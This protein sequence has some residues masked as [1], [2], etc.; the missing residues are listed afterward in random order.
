[1]CLW[2]PNWPIQRLR[3]VQRAHESH[4]VVL[5]TQTGSR[6]AIVTHTSDE[7]I[8][9]GV[10]PGMPLADAQALL[11]ATASPHPP[12][13]SDD[14][15][16]S[17][18]HSLVH[19]ATHL[20]EADLEHL[21]TLA[22]HCQ[23]RY[24]PLVGLEEAEMPES[25]L[26][27]VTG[28][29][30]LFGGEVAL[31]EEISQDFRQNHF[32]VRIALAD[33]IGA[34]WAFAHYG[35]SPT[36]TAKS[37]SQV[38]RSQVPRPNTHASRVSDSPTHGTQPPHPSAIFHIPHSSSPCG[39]TPDNNTS[40]GP[41]SAA[42][43]MRRLPI[44]AL[45]LPARIVKTLRELDLYQIGQ[46]QDLPRS[47]LPSRFGPL[48]LQRLD[49]ALGNAVELLRLEQPPDPITAGREFE[50]PLTSQK[51][52]QTILCE[53]LTD[54]LEQLTSRKLGV[55]QLKCELEIPAEKPSDHVEPTVLSIGLLRPSQQLRQLQELVNMRLEHASLPKEISAVRLQ[56]DVT[57]SLQNRQTALFEMDSQ[58]EN[59]IAQEN[60]INRLSNRL[61]RQAVVRPALYPDAQPEY[62]V[63]YTPWLETT[64]A[65]VST[66]A[67]TRRKASTPGSP[68][69]SLVTFAPARLLILRPSVLFLQPEEIRTWALGPEGPPVRFCWQNR[70]HTVAYSWG[71]ERI[72]TGWW[73]SQAAQR[74]YYRVETTTGRR[75]WL[76]RRLD[77]GRWLLHGEY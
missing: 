74:D 54:I 3:S 50:Y 61:G 75:F 1:M 64:P 55:L 36:P 53:L 8:R 39:R 60:L 29:T 33:T 30:H 71:P 2:L 67:T 17:S 48:V 21:Q 70:E 66:P 14:K 38:S 43:D 35:Q 77:T 20:P 56:A 23:Q 25:L 16:G 52:L 32:Q 59:R 13:S 15:T 49:Q 63:R 11:P 24:T 68:A 62:A 69:P 19:F 73:R 9:L 47:S 40:R 22:Y 57:A 46:L 12:S 44:E 42:F 41:K 10:T 27:D 28:C 5:F 65:H 51:A 34:A 31:A 6:G 7:A 26:L 58:R 76:F 4:P 45:R 72:D 37:R 18:T